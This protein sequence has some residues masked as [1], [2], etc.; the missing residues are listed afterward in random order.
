M[1]NDNKFEQTVLKFINP[2]EIKNS[3]INDS[4][5]IKLKNEPSNIKL[6]LKN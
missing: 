1:S 6:K 3:I 5:N 2:S 4:S